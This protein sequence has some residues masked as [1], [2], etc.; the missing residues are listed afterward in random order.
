V[1]H[2]SLL[3]K[4]VSFFLSLTS[5]LQ[6]KNVLQRVTEIVQKK[7]NNEL[8]QQQPLEANTQ[9]TVENQHFVVVFI[10]TN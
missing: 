5:T 2:S 8:K 9:E 4:V 3:L 6:I 10:K 7:Q 1:G